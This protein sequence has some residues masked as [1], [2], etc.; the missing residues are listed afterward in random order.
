MNLFAYG[1][2]MNKNILKVVVGGVFP[3]KKAI[4]RGYKLF[5]PDTGYPYI[6]AK[7]DSV[8]EGIV[9]S[10][11]DKE[12][13]KLI[14]TYEDEGFYY[15]RIK[16]NVETEDGETVE[17]YV[18]V[19]NL[20]NIKKVWKDNIDI[21]VIQRVEEFIEKKIG[22]KISIKRDSKDSD[23]DRKVKIEIL[24][25]DIHKLIDLYLDGKY[26]SNY[27]VNQ[28]INLVKIPKINREID[29]T[30]GV[31]KNYIGL[32]YDVT[33]INRIEDYLG[34]NFSKLLYYKYPLYERTLSIIVSLMMFN[35]YRLYFEKAKASILRNIKNIDYLDVIKKAI[36]DTERFINTHTFEL[37]YT[38]KEIKMSL[39]PGLLTIG[40]EMEFS[41]INIQDYDDHRVFK[42]DKKYNG[43][44]YFNDFDLYRRMWKLGGHID[45]HT[46]CSQF[47]KKGGFLEI[48]LGK[49]P[50]SDMS[51]PITKSLGIAEMLIKETIKFFDKVKPHS[52]HVNLEYNGNIDWKRENDI[53]II[54]C[55]MLIA[56]DFKKLKNGVIV[57]NRMYN[58]EIVKDPSGA[59]RIICENS[60]HCRENQEKTVIEYQFPRL[61]IEKDYF[62]IIGAIKGFQ[63]GYKPRPFGSKVRVVKDKHIKEESNIIKKWA[64]NVKPVSK[65]VI[66]K[67]ISYVDYGFAIERKERPAHTKKF[68]ENLLFKIEKEI[69]S[70]NDN[71][72]DPITFINK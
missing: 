18:Y 27:E 64:F 63:L 66:E 61:S 46:I 59:Y 2:L 5:S 42:S 4:L 16:V 56:G 29:I 34:D 51:L 33:C 69:K 37:E 3:N 44:L 65:N 67:F 55:L 40:V 25:A 8:V 48:T 19:G 52:L 58:N 7:E 9:Y 30:L 22:E 11:I 62:T 71:I 70:V 28:E 60:H 1:T 39:N 32:V 47:E 10:G 36:I 13:F 72:S 17:S 50:F 54:K 45:N 6:V 57:E 24:K 26:L 43:F 68:I 38:S 31:L 41:N 15:N 21:D 23:I 12:S 14:D 35:K 20:Y 53:E 49:E